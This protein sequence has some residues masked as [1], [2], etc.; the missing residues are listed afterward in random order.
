MTGRYPRRPR[1]SSGASGRASRASRE[2]DS[3][4]AAIPAAVASGKPIPASGQFVRIDFSGPR[5]HALGFIG[6]A[7]TARPPPG[8]ASLAFFSAGPASGSGV[9]IIHRSLAGCPAPG[10]EVCGLGGGGYRVGTSRV[11][12]GS[13][14]NVFMFLFGMFHNEY[15]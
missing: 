11:R 3:F 7:K 10:P 14:E 9:K 12:T 6:P 13:V 15:Q 5:A 1:F 2:S 8:R 4:P